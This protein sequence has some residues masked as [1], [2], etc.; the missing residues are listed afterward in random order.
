MITKCLVFECIVHILREIYTCKLFQCQFVRVLV[1][2]KIIILT[3]LL[4]DELCGYCN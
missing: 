1:C 4:D 2:D 3:L